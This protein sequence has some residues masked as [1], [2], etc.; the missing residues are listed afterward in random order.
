MGVTLQ[1]QPGRVGARGR[2]GSR[3]Q[4]AQHGLPVLAGQPRKLDPPRAG[5][6]GAGQIGLGNG[7]GH[8]H[9]PLG[10]HAHDRL[11]RGHDLPGFHLH[12][13]HHA[14]DLAHQLAVAKG[15]VRL[16]RLG[17]GRLQPGLCHVHRGASPIHVGAAHEIPGVQPLGAL[18]VGLGQLQLAT[19]RQLIGTAGV[20]QRLE[21][22]GID[23]GQHLADRHGI[24]RVHLSLDDAP[25]G[26][27][28]IAD[29]GACPHLTGQGP[30][31]Q[32]RRGPYH[33]G[34]YRPGRLFVVRGLLATT[35]QQ[36]GSEAGQR[37]C[38]ERASGQG[39][40]GQTADHDRHDER[41]SLSMTDES[42]I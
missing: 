33:L 16:V 4:F 42:S 41:R 36:E 3:R 24:A 12:G 1:G 22:H 13:R 2:I 14:I 26:L 18:Q 10:R 31:I 32:E 21:V 34:Q 25:P 27:E 30:A 9:I 17:V 29:L 37:Q 8:F 15:V 11:T 35:D 6:A 20:D 23:A 38:P 28:G 39:R 19:G 7:H 5:R 40:W